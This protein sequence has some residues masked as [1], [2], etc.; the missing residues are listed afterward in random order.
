MGKKAVV[1]G[2]GLWLAV[3]QV[4]LS[5]QIPSHGLLREVWEGISGT[6]VS[7]LTSHPLFPDHPTSSNYVTDL[8]ES[9]TDILEQYGQRMH[10]YL[11]APQ[12]GN[13]TFWLATDD[14]GSLL[15]STDEQP[16]NAREI[17]YVSG[18]TPSREWNWEA[19]QQSAP[20]YLVA[21]QIYYI[22]AFMKE[23]GGGDNL[24]VR[25][26]MP[27]GTDQAPIL[28]THFLPY[29]I[30]FEPPS[31][32]VQPGNT[33]VVEGGVASFG[34][35][36]EAPGIYT[37][38]WQRNGLNLAGAN[39][40][41]LNYG[42]VGLGES[43]ARFRVVVSNDLGT[44][45][46]T[47]AI[48]TV[49]PDTTR[50]ALVGVQNLGSTQLEVYFS[51]PVS[52]AS[53]ALASNYGLSGGASVSAATMGA[54]P[55]TVVLTV[56]SLTFGVSYTLTVNGVRDTAQAPNTI[57]ANSQAV[58]VATE[59]A[60]TDVGDP[61]VEGGTEYGGGAV[62][63]MGSGDLGGTGDDFHYSWQ[64]RTGDF[65]LRARLTD[66]DP[67]DPF[68]KAGL[69][70]RDT[71][72]R[73]S[74]FVSALATPGTVGC[75]FMA[76]TREGGA[77]TTSGY[78]PVNYP[79]TWLRLRR[80]GNTFT[81]FASW[82]GVQWVQ[83]GA[84]TLS[85]PS[86]V[87]YGLVATSRSA[88]SRAVASFVDLGVVTTSSVTTYTPS[89][90]LPGPSSRF[91]PLVI[92]E[93]MYHPKE[94]GDGVS[95]E[96][97]EIYNADAVSQDLTGYRISGSVD[98]AFPDGQLVPAGGFV[99]VARDPVEFGVLYPGVEALGPFAGTNNLPN[100]GGLV[101]LRNGWGAV[102]LEV[103][104]GTEPPWSAAAD[105]AGCSLVLSR[106][107]YGEGDVRAW[108]ASR[109]VGGSPGAMETQGSEA[110]D[111]VMINEFLAHTDDPEVDYVELFNYSDVAVDVSG[112]FLTD[113]PS[114]NRFRIPNGTIIP[115]RGL[116]AF[117]QNQ[118]GYR[119]DA[120]GETLFL[121]HSNGTRVLD[122][123]RFGPQENGVASG[124]SPDGS[125][126]I[127]RLSELTPGS[128]NAPFR[129][130]EVVINEIMY[131]PIS[132][133]DE[134]EFVE[135]HNRSAAAVDLSGW[136]L[137]D[138]VDYRFPEGTVL[139]A[140]GYFVVGRNR[141]KL[142]S[143][144]PGVAPGL[145]FGDFGGVLSNGG[146]RLALARPDVIL[147]TNQFGMVETNHV[148][149]EVDEVIYGTGGRW[150][151][152]SDGLG[153][154]L[155]LIDAD[156]DHLRPSNWADSDETA[157]AG[158]STIE[159]TGRLDNGDGG[160]AD[161][162]QIMMQGAGECL[163]DNVEVIP[164]G[165]ANVLAN[166]GFSSSLSG[167]T[168]GGNHRASSRDAS[169]GYGG[170][171]CLHVRATGRGDTACNRIYS[172]V[173]PAP[174]SGTVA[175]LRAR[176]RWLRGWPEFMLRLRGNYLEAAGRMEVPAN[177]GTPGARNSR[178]VAN[179]A[180][181]IFDVQHAPVLPGSGQAVVVSARVSDPDG[182]GPVTLKWHVDQTTTTNSVVMRDDGTNGDLIAG[183]GIYSARITG[184]SGGTLASFHVEASDG[185]ATGRFPADAPGREC[186]IRWGESQ[187]VGN[188]GVYRLWQ[189]A[190]DYNWL[191][192][193]ESLANDNVD[194]TFVYDN[195]RVVYNLEMRGKGS[196][197]HGGSVGSDYV[198]AFPD[199][200]RFLGAQ[201]VALVTVGNLGN[202][203]TAQREQAA[204]WIGRGMGIPTLNRRH[205]LFFENGS[206]KQQVYE[207]TEEPNGLYADRWWPEG[208]DG[209]LYKVEDWFEFNAEGTGFTF[210]RDATLEPFTT[211][212][213]SYKLARYRWSWRKRA[214]VNSSNDYTN[215]FN[216]VRAVNL[217]GTALVEQTENLVD[218]ENWMG[219][220]A[221][222]HIVGNWD[223]YG[224]NRGKNAYI[225]KP[226]Q[227]RFGMVP[228]DIDFVLGSGSDGPSTDIFSSNDPTIHRLWDTAPFRRMYLRAFLT[229]IDGPLRAE[230]FDP[231][232][233]A[234]YAALVANGVSVAGPDAT[235]TWVGQRRNYLIG[236]IGS[237]DTST[238]AITSNGGNNFST[239]ASIAT[240][241]GSAPLRVAAIAVNGAVVP[242]TWTGVTTWS[243][244]LALGARTN[245]LTFVGLDR[246]GRPIGG[247]S[248][249]ITIEYTGA[250]LPS[251]V[252]QVVINEIMYNPARQ[253]ASFVEIYNTST[254][255][256]CDL[257]GWRLNGVDFD[258]PAGTLLGPRAY[259]VV[260]ANRD[261]FANAFGFSVSPVGE[262]PGGLQKDG[263][264]LRL[265]RPGTGGEPDLLVDQVR[266]GGALPW[267]PEANGWG[268]SLQLIDPLQ[269]NWRV[270]NWACSA[271]NAAVLATPGQANSV[272]ATLAAYPLV[273]INEVLPE[274]ILGVTDRFG[275]R[276]PWIEL[277]NAGATV[278]D[279][280]GMGLSDDP[281]A[282]TRWTFPS[283]TSLGANQY[284]LIWADGEAGESVAGELHAN[285]RLTPNQGMVLLARQQSGRTVA[286]DYL[287]YASQP[288]GLSYGSYPNG[289][290]QERMLFHTLTPGAVNDAAVAPVMVLVNEWMASNSG[291][292]LDPADGDADDWFELY[293]AGLEPTDL[294]AYT[295]S[296]NPADPAKYVIP[297]GTVI[298]AGGYLLF[299]ADDEV[300]QG[301]DGS[302]H[303]NFK[304]AESGEALGL[305]DPNGDPVDEVAF[306]QQVANL[307]EGRF[308]DGMSE[309]FVTLETPS[310]GAANLFA[311]ANRPP[312][313]AAIGSR[314]LNEGQTLSLV[315]SATDEDAG[316]SLS[317]SL[318][319]AP[320]G[321]T[322]H[323]TTGA[324]TW[325]TGEADG[326]GAYAF[327]VRVTDNGVPP[328]SDSE[329]IVVTVSEVNVA[330]TLAVLSNRTVDEG[331]LL[332][333]TAVAQDSDLPAQSLVFSLDAG[334]P[335]GATVDAATGLFGWTPT[336][337][338]GQGNYTVTLRVTDNAQPAGTAT[339]SFTVT[340]NEVDD[341]PEFTPV[342]L[343]TVDELSPF[344]LTVV[345]RDP[346]TPSKAV[347]YS[348]VSG[349][350]GLQVAS[351]TGV[352][353]WT[354]SEVQ[355]PGSYNV[356]IRASEVGGSRNSTLVFSIV[357][358]EANQAPQLAPIAGRTV[359]EG[360]VVEFL[361]TATDADLPAQVLSY[362]LDNGAPSGATIDPS[363]GWFSWPIE[364][365]AGASTNVI[366]VRVRDDAVQAR[367][368]SVT[369]TVV[370]RAVPRI[371]IN[372]IMYHPSAVGA[373]YVELFNPS[374]RTTWS[375]AG[376]RLTGTAFTFPS[377]ASLPP[378][379]Y[380]VVAENVSVCASTYSLSGVLGNYR[381]EL[382]PAAPMIQL[383]R[384]DGSGSETLVD[385]VSFRS[386]SPWPALANGGGASLQLIDPVQDNARVAN[387]AAV[388]G[389]TTNA[390]R[391][392]VAME[393]SWRYWQAA[394]DPTAG[395]TNRTYN[396]S[397][398]PQGEALLYAES[399]E[400]P[401][402]KSTEL[403][404][405][406]MSYLFRGRFNYSGNPEGALL[407]LTLV[408][409]DGAVIYLNG[410]PV[411]WL[412]MAEGVIPGRSEAA[413]R[414]VADAIL[415]GPFEVPATGL[416]VGENVLA[417]QVHQV[418][419]GSSD[420]VF[421]LAANVVEVRR[422]AFT[423]GYANSARATLDP[424]PSLYLSE[425]V[426]QNVSGITDSAG[427][428]DPWI[429][430][431]NLGEAADLTG[432][433]LGMSYADPSQW[434]FPTG[435]TVGAG[436]YP[437]V[438]AD[439]EPGE[440]SAGEWHTNFRLP[441]SSGVVVLS[442][443][444]NGSPVVVDFLEYAGVVADQAYGFAEPGRP[445]EL[446]VVLSD[447]TPGEANGGGSDFYPE[448]IGL[449]A[450][451]GGP[452]ILL[453]SSMPGRS[454]EVERSDDLS[455][456][457]WT[458]LGSLTASGAET[459]WTDEEGGEADRRFYRVLLLP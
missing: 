229:A 131:H 448:F 327:T 196:P 265:V 358:N 316:Q 92:S 257:S 184:R 334:A 279:L 99:V 195:S 69:M 39:S 241:V 20:I 126:D 201:D 185:A 340:V 206:R 404:L 390:P 32:A 254:T 23:E 373:E 53:A 377:G 324:F 335:A 313:L 230:E 73:G 372:E 379:G 294:S 454:Y 243:I 145:I 299:W 182:V 85:L 264:R 321:A 183:D 309:P 107:S 234:R 239:S 186:L 317:Y 292:V 432:Y 252:D 228:W 367:E 214:V 295:L 37:F 63:V 320:A 349:P 149:I 75:F 440:T 190:V 94:R 180:P 132:D 135:L 430:L 161:R 289:Q 353:T 169:G 123:V 174:A 114:T 17:A 389:T 158:W 86:T 51:E 422:D 141:A 171:G 270:G 50:P 318:L 456:S 67:T 91:T 207:D 216:L 326:P 49:V 333:F 212:D 237:M 227:G 111:A 332:T 152:W 338:Q 286:V 21:G 1:V 441:T 101:R 407:Q 459:G 128:E 424:F 423:P 431:S 351:G 113:D 98:F 233:E 7:D 106:P 104:Y 376:W 40:Y 421:G 336:E 83:L 323:P 209:D 366:T 442:R 68:A 449:T 153:S 220:I 10:G 202:D 139:P 315:A 168:V 330:P 87:Y 393:S 31:I 298:P 80:V 150:G 142:I 26:R 59:Y 274:N 231:M 246:D 375:L 163:V 341:A 127:R 36:L 96:F 392:V 199:D 166:P 176:V 224:Y 413:S 165:G 35:Q 281:A 266:Y 369:F 446:G 223:A 261:G 386:R 273:F 205:V 55:T 384:P 297:N 72:G 354:P 253:G 388:S 451:P 434:R 399:A 401:A 213:G 301:G 443:M 346:D 77:A 138:G 103:E 345:A 210:S 42:P 387:W 260:A 319:G 291:V 97:I 46:S 58:F 115:S 280:S 119:L 378:G 12:T 343:Q 117:D 54:V 405:G 16:G 197:W 396:D 187:P 160:A 200:D 452:V 45:S 429:E 78:L 194:A 250:A 276:D 256:S 275:D 308:P 398:W 18:W 164:S 433:A 410:N 311:T 350:S 447:P 355:G 328:R 436:S 425:V 189:R 365:D 191:R 458:S 24:A 65:D 411:L 284:L 337:A 383:W 29:G 43:G 100:D 70:V 64:R 71:L 172:A 179:A 414:T 310:P 394:S 437:L 122:A 193:R 173:S 33:T 219:T 6:A 121:V 263:E 4:E 177:L 56:S 116:L 136:S 287:E 370:V 427:D 382:D 360:T 314:L 402:A 192:S 363:T 222:Q 242:V 406:Q 428:R 133:D 8:F 453:W 198:F 148:D 293:N 47:E 61:P 342:G 143:N 408:L 130:C 312:V 418:N 240:L 235:K 159:F 48:L 175:T 426:V 66:F 385:W 302:F 322:I 397:T 361:A 352:V 356:E 391:N 188:L 28:G 420:V 157:K 244:R 110:L 347:T 170:G 236:R 258:F 381:D 137:S 60:P 325:S 215:L 2:A 204:F 348:L 305:Y 144:H 300:S 79:N 19:N 162:L 109:F 95:G 271:T 445:G 417:V 211:T 278:V 93:I 30:S 283:G 395:W 303:V 25:W 84:S 306:G 218:M 339:R 62:R 357:V 331:T 290:P 167:W 400:L 288:A 251:P 232:V 13:Y 9:P 307:S 3:L 296:D 22:S 11:V 269:D 419:P 5:A 344:S 248:D 268:P 118:L 90:E 221:L 76:R 438:W 444:Q 362:S 226:V 380:L 450:E 74:R 108:G 259:A 374:E 27:D 178:A 217:S 412:G 112:C 52:T 247:V 282:L 364:A 272:A 129:L 403:V 34:V 439:G 82:D 371:V 329:A 255:A 435:A 146:E 120:T 147:S 102:L 457:N 181:A 285:F 134:D 225:Y 267:P 124:R 89:G 151:K 277:Y 416:V 15:L 262:Y 38:Q 105:G 57:L 249:T 155:E 238:F 368:A 88:G 409:D 14:G 41:Q 359:G 245:P 203:D 154:S 208:P 125:P 455:G 156:S 140:G 44:A 304:L 81:A 415:E